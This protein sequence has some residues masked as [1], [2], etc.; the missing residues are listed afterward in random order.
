[1]LDHHEITKLLYE[2]C[3]GCDRMDQVQMAGVYATESWDDHGTDK[4]PGQ[5]FT[6]RT[7]VGLRATNMCSHLMGQ[8]L[9]RI[10]GD[11]AGA[12]S[13]FI[14]TVRYPAKDG[15]E[16]LNQLG[17][18]YVDTLVREAGRWRI[19]KRICVRD[20]S[21]RV[22]IADDWLDGAGFVEG[23]RSNEDP[24]FAV[25]GIAHSGPPRRGP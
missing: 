23:K 20:W 22:P 8:S 6:A 2:Y 10:N 25:L 3:H 1:M 24:S 11:E 14:A 5:E 17:G 18:R 19:K 16:T 21:I 13:H 12:E 4:C 7:M 15:R 9:I